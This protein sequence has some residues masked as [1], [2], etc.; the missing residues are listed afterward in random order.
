MKKSI[1]I[2]LLSAGIFTAKYSS[3]QT[4]ATSSTSTSTGTSAI[5]NDT[6]A[7]NFIAQATLGNMKEIETGKLAVK[8]AKKASVK[9]FGARMI[10]DHTKAT[11]DMQ[12]VLSSKQFTAPT[13]SPADAAPDAMLTSATG[14]E[15]DKNYITMMMMDHVKTV[16]VFQNAIANVQDPDLK[17]FAVKTLPVIQEHLRMDKAIAKELNIKTD[18]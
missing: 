15:F 9:T 14:T 4:T 16:Q 6:A 12:K 7:V 3:A 18:M 2:L 5:A 13:P 10:A 17:A 1:A 8:K 11:A